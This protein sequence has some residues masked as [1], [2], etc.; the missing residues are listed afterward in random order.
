MLVCFG[1]GFGLDLVVSC[2]ELAASKG[3]D[4]GSETWRGDVAFWAAI[5]PEAR[6][7]TIVEWEYG[8]I[9]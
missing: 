1:L 4:W 6:V 2:S 8:Y 3:L 9:V 7:G 5:L